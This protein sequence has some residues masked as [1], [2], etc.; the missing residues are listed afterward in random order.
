MRPFL[1]H[2][3]LLVLSLSIESTAWGEHGHRTV[4]YLARLYFTPE[5]EALFNELVA[6]N[7]IFDISDGAVWA[8]NHNVQTKMPY[9]KPWHYID[10]KDNPPEKCIINYSRDCH[11]DKHCIISAI[12]NM[13]SHSLES[14]PS[15]PVYQ[16]TPSA[17][18]LWH[19]KTDFPGQ[20]SGNH[21]TGAEQRFQIPP[22]FPRRCDTAS[23]HRRKM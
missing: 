10:A 1:V 19:P 8:D 7:E 20:Q 2:T 18:H 23:S 11:P 13:V 22:P 6:P 16:Y 5:G 21:K 4:G 14:L 17:N 12:V 3:L 15:I 9:S